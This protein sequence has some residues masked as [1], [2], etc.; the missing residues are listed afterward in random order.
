MAQTSTGARTG[1]QFLDGLRG[2]GRELWLEGE[3]IDDPTAHP[4]LAGAA[5][6]LARVFD[7]QHEEPEVFLMPS[8]DT[9]Q[10]VNVTHVQPT[11]REDLERRRQASKRIA[12]ETAGMMGRTPDYL[13]YTFACFAA[14]ADVW[15]R[16]GNERGAE[17]IVALPAPDARRRSSARRTRS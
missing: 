16:Y 3:Q 2:D 1:E 9:G 13:N 14:R 6:A 12:E 4:K 11:A 15:A 8:P 5:R 7:L 10:P 17:N